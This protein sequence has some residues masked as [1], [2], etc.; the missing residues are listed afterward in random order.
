MFAARSY[1]V[2]RIQHGHGSDEWHDMVDVTDQDS[3]KQDPERG[4]SRGRI[5]R[6]TTCSDEIRIDTPQESETGGAR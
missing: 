6:C 3:T 2:A 5:F 4:W 1:E